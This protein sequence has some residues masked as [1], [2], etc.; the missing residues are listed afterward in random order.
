M[1]TESTCGQGV[2]E[3]SILPARLADLM[4][5]M[6]A[7]LEVHQKALDRTDPNAELE[8]EAYQRVAQALRRSTSELEATSGQMAA[9]RTVPMGRHDTEALSS[10]PAVQAFAAFVAAEQEL[11]ALLR[12]RV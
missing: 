6:A 9:S 1:E 8:F 7:V 4:A 10:P 2:A 3:S 11:L 12:D 5:S